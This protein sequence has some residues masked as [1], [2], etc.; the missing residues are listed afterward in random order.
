MKDHRF[1]SHNRGADAPLD[2]DDLELRAAVDDNGYCIEYRET[3]L[4]HTK[5]LGLIMRENKGVSW[6]KIGLG[7]A[8]ELAALGI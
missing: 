6:T 7:K 1:L 5:R 8:F 3:K 2:G 4:Q